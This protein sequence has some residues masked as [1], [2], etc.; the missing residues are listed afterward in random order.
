M[1]KQFKEKAYTFTLIL[2]LTALVF[3]I[4]AFFLY[5]KIEDIVI[6]E[7]NK[8]AG[9]VAASVSK[10]IELD[11]DEY[12]KLSSALENTAGG[13]NIDYYVRMSGLLR[14]IKK[15]P[16]A[17]FIYTEKWLSEESVAYVLD[18]EDPSSEH[19]SALGSK[20]S[21][22]EL[23]KKSFK[24]EEDGSLTGL[25]EDE[26]WGKLISGFAPIKNKMTGTTV[27][28]VGV[29]FS[30]LYV[31]GAMTGMRTL[32]IIGLLG[33]I[34]LVTAI[35]NILLVIRQK[36]INMDY[37]TKLYNKR[38]FDISIKK[39]VKEASKNGVFFSL[40]IIDID[41]FKSINDQFGHLA[42]DEI[43]KEIAATIKKSKRKDDLCFR[44]GGDEFIV[45]LPN[46]T[47]E[48]ASNI[49]D[50]IQSKLLSNSIERKELSDIRISI[51][52][53]IAQWKPG[54]SAS[55]LTKWTDRAMYASKNKGKNQMT[56]SDRE[57]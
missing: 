35:I 43:L 21:I 37:M 23:E 16:E 47:K 2:L 56:L 46:T 25:V 45:I 12:E 26:I 19:Y 4:P 20:G 13:Y 10:F 5:Q 6:K 17:K 28:L 51:S 50:K 22:S 14:D 32:I 7:T 3:S 40:M 52:I 36:T 42:G 53:G 38:F 18:G 8:K 29:D 33:A 48:Q 57:G 24:K 49:G 9:T 1:K 30:P 55:D 44:F 34:L 39:A 41:N 15:E 54:M 31:K 27:G 11:I